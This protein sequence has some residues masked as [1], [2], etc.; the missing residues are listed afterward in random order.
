MK[1]I[2]TARY[3]N[4]F[5]AS[6]IYLCLSIFMFT[7]FLSN[8]SYAQSIYQYTDN[9]LGVPFAVN[10]NAT[11]G[12]LTLGS[13]LNNTSLTCTGLTDGFG[14]K[15]WYAGTA[16][17]IA[18]ANTNG[19]YVSITI[20]P[21]TGY[22]LNITGFQA[23]FR[24]PSSGSGGPTSVR[25]A[26]L[27]NGSGFT[28]NGSSI[29]PGTSSSCTNA[30]LTGTWT[31]PSA[32]ETTNSV[33]LRIFGFNASVANAE[34]YLKTININGSVVCNPAITAS[35]APT[36]P[37]I[38]VNDA[39]TLTG[40]TSGGTVPTLSHSWSLT[41]GAS[42]A[43]LS[44]P[45]TNITNLVSGTSGG[46]AT[47]QY[48]ASYGSSPSCSVSATRNIVVNPLPSLTLGTNP[49]V[50]SGVTTAN[51]T[52]SNLTG[53]PNV[54][55]I[56]FDAA[57]EAQGFVDAINVSSVFTAPISIAV[58]AAATPGTYNAT[59]VVENNTVGCE[60]PVYNLVII[61]N[62]LPSVSIVG[63]ST[64][65]VGATSALFN[66][67]NPASTLVWS[68]SNTTAATVSNLGVVSGLSAGNTD[69]TYTATDANG[70]SKTTPPFAITVNPLPTGTLTIT[71]TSGT[72]ND[73]GTVC[74]GD[75]ATVTAPS[76]YANYK[77]LDGTT[78]LQNGASNVYTAAYTSSKTITVEITTAANC[79]A[80]LSGVTVTVGT[81]AVQNVNTGIN[82]ASIQTAINA[83]TAGDVITVGAGNYQSVNIDKS[84]TLKGANFG[85]ACA[86][87][88]S[89]ESNI[90]GIT[91]GL[92]AVTISASNVIF[93]GFQ[94]N[95]MAGL[96]SGITT[97]GTSNITDITIKNNKVSAIMGS[98]GIN[99]QN[100][101]T[102]LAVENNC[103]TIGGQVIPVPVANTTTIG[104]VT[105]TISGSSAASIKDNN[106]TGGFYGHLVHNVNT[107][108]QTTVKGGTL[109]G[110]MQSVAVVNTLNGTNLFPSN[111]KVDGVNMSGFTGNYTV[112]PAQNF[113]AGIYTFTAGASTN[114][115]A[116]TV[117]VDGVT[118]DGTQKP[119]QASAG[120]YLG[121][122]SSAAGTFQ[123]VTVTNSVIQNNLNRG[124]S[125]R[126][127]VN[128]TI[129]ANT[130]TNNGG[131]AFGTGGNDG[132]TIIAQQGATV[133][134][135]NNFITHPATSTT[136]VIAFQVGNTPSSAF[137]ATN[138]SIL[139][140]GNTNAKGANNTSGNATMIA[141]CNWWGGIAGTVA[142]LITG[143]V[144]FEQFL[145]S[146]TDNDG[147]T[148]GFQPAP[149][150]CN[151]CSSGNT[152]TNT[153]TGKTYCTI[154][155]AINDVTTV[156]GNTIT[157]SSGNYNE[158]VLVNKEVTIK[159][160]GTTKPIINLTGTPA[161]ASGKLTAFEVVVPNVKIE[162]LEFRIDISKLGSAIVASVA[163]PGSVS[164]LSIKGNEINPYR[165][166]STT[167][168]F[169]SRNAVNIN[170]GG[171]RIN[172][173]NPTGIL[174]Q[175]NIVSYSNGVDNTA[176]TAD[177]AGFRAGFAM[178][179]GTGDFTGNTIQTISQDI[180]VR[181]TN[182]ANNINI[183]N[184]NINGGG[185]NYAAPNISG[186]T[187]TISGNAF[188]GAAAS[189]VPNSNLLRIRDNIG[190]NTITTVVS[191]NTFINHTWALSLENYKNVTVN[192][193]TF[194]PL[195]NSTNYHH[196][197]VNTK[198]NA[199]SS[200][201]VAQTAIDG[202]F[203][204][205][206]FNGSGTLG[207][208]ALKFL[209]HDNDDAT[210]GTFTVGTAGNENNFNS[211]IQ[212]FIAF[213]AQTGSSNGATFPTY[214][215]TGSWPT[216]MAP[217]NQNIDARFNKFDV[218]GSLKLP[219]AMNLTERTALENALMH[220]PDN[221]ALGVIR[222]FDPVHN[223][224]Q[225]T[226]FST[227]Q[228]AITAAVA[229]DVIELSEW[230]FTE[231]ITIDKTLTVQGVDSSSVILD[232]ATIADANG[233]TIANGV[234]GV[235]IK[236]LKIKNFKGAAPLGSG[237]YG[238]S[239]NNNLMIDGV[240]LDNNQGRG[241]VFLSGGAG[242]SNVT[243]KNS[244]S[245]NHTVAG[246]RAI[247]IWDGFKE[248][249]TITGNKVY[250][251]NCC[252]I[253]L[254]DGTASAVNI[255][256]N[257]IQIGTGDNAI[258]LMGLR[259][260]TGANTINNNIITGGGRFG[261][262]I[263]NPNGGGTT[264]SGNTV[265]L[266]IQNT[267]VR[268]RAGI[269]VFRRS[270]TAGNTDNHP[271]APNGV[272]ISGNTVEGYQQ[273]SSSDGFG[274]VVEG[275]NHTIS[276]NILN[277]NDVGIQQQAGHTPFTSNNAGDG[278]QSDVA[279]NYFGRGNSPTLC[280]ITL[281]GNTYSGNGVNERIVMGG[282]TGTIVTAITPT[283]SDPA[284]QSVCVGSSS[285]AV[286]FAGNNLP[287]VVYNWTNT[288]T[289]IG[290]AASG[291]GDISAFTVTNTTSSP[292]MATITVTP[293]ANGCSGTP[294]TFTITVDPA[295]VG[296]S[297]AGGTT[298]CTGTN[299]TTLTLS[300]NVGTV[301]KWQSASD[302]AFTS[303]TDIANT[304]TTLIATNLTA[305]TYYRAV[306]QSGVCAT[307]NSGNAVVTVD[308]AS[309]GGIIAG[310][311]SVCTGTNSTTLTLN[312][313][314]G[315]VVKWQSSSDMAFTS[316][317][318]IANTTTT[319]TVSNLT[320]TTYYRAVVQ[321]GVCIPANSGSAV[322][323]V[324]PVSVGGA[325][326]S[327]ATVCTGINSTNL[328]LTGNL[329]TVVK[330]QSSLLG[331][332]SD[333]VDIVNTTTS[334][335]ATNL[336]ATTSFRAVVQ[337]GTCSSANSAKATVTV[338]PASV[339]GTVGSD[340]TVC[341]GTN[342]TT[343]S[344]TGNV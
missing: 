173:S 91:P 321:S 278:N 111:V 58:P 314:V 193:N 203:T 16:T 99:V 46:T 213:D 80:T 101:G 186:G 68:S 128:A 47:A 182:T 251:N 90:S 153:N 192:N 206:T 199:S 155:A 177:D 218:S 240:V 8:T 241:G 234:T 34:M 172:T 210:Y 147:G 270:V 84:L 269:A 292:I 323:T 150:T 85:V 214:P 176:G 264:V 277:N 152:I 75:A 328:I 142:P 261:I 296:G 288:N 61:V 208:T 21:K 133:T 44:N 302:M 295:S 175:N 317:M 291:M 63:G 205:N 51:L 169:G 331:D 76:G 135:E 180:E 310:G 343:L 88:R 183:T 196:I 344:L 117:N 232:G 316:P 159:G 279:D 13:G 263:K 303:P 4:A 209:N 312:N 165:S 313:H 141:T 93:D 57:A 6:Q 137:T 82:Y 116:L 164:N 3:L 105:N 300:G 211:G 60:S 202:T 297:I 167:V 327:D 86:G 110:Q 138:N 18:T 81:C 271:D 187:L 294:Q 5:K 56:N 121:D 181:F 156:A 325:V 83:A 114:A 197:T 73:D 227:I 242:I 200:S 191:N 215:S 118:I 304:T 326:G 318:D 1:T 12:N 36:T 96:G 151:G 2:F 158:Q 157:L 161:L 130:F 308:A 120:V 148:S 274:I 144:S 204:N 289:A 256:N 42:F 333:A 54:Y 35:I 24:S 280:N 226:Y 185:V 273:S 195:A 71:E 293:V 38:C 154:Q 253:E 92:P 285:T 122:F 230:T 329:G 30:G 89:A 298:V 78:T 188:N 225:N 143:D 223:I 250:N 248:N 336:T 335:T 290:L 246:S 10:S 224:T 249:I 171:F 207:G 228:P 25:F 255:S 194:T 184:N 26:Y 244:I 247:V 174:A 41:S 320:A 131:D 98:Y 20:S 28:E 19:K 272:T 62:A 236:N 322:I 7:L 342:T 334:Y 338:D 299:S 222:Y 100:V 119:N 283:V 102:P 262:E 67:T 307:A 265:T 97:V 266:S 115:S 319:L 74:S 146:G 125:V 66:I 33:E 231:G 79:T 106:I 260:T 52:Y 145:T 166:S 340:A 127:K 15:D 23:N 190:A 201:T 48:T 124:V 112:I 31:L 332:F 17:T 27:I 40:A 168:A 109:T 311:T 103:V 70:C 189:L 309:V 136:P 49:A 284:D 43:T 22:K 59:F 39:V 149:G 65:C 14:A 162:N 108:S 129:T 11:G 107:T 126:G 252:G 229:N 245:K 257:T 69:I 77:F 337:N 286:T 282:G 220:K 287:G 212:N 341:T 94:V 29:N 53:N 305:T 178:D 139:M 339:G 301:V 243:V 87:T 221:A 315:I 140:N 45:T 179:E 235:T 259:N 104:I 281:S 219:S 217:W 113:H 9:S 267:D 238:G 37:T 198:E 64:V 32:I 132:Y 170:Y 258:G 123:T 216:T 163:L 306:V 95:G 275:E 237:I 134:S 72:T 233:I 268:D 55:S 239:G 254:Q 50:C 324:D 160:T 330:W 276:N